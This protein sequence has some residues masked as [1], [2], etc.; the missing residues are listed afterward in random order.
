[1]KQRIQKERAVSNLKAMFLFNLIVKS[2]T[3]SLFCSFLLSSL[4]G[5][6]DVVMYTH[7]NLREKFSS[8]IVTISVAEADVSTVKSPAT[9]FKIF[10][11]AYKRI[12]PS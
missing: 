4:I 9:L 12:Q 11:G 7:C 10:S 3:F 5:T 2:M 1:M 8:R 6:S